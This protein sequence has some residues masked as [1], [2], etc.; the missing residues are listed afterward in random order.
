VKGGTFGLED[1]CDCPGDGGR[2][3]QKAKEEG[4]LQS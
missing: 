2:E 1:V 3:E 4:L